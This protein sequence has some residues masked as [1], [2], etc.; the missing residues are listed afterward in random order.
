MVDFGRDLRA[1][2]TQPGG[3]ELILPPGYYRCSRVT[4]APHSD[5]LVLRAAEPGSVAVDSAVELN[6]TSRLVTAGLDFRQRFWLNSGNQNVVSWHCQHSN[7]GGGGATNT[8]RSGV[9]VSGGSLTLAGADVRRCTQDGVHVSGAAS[10][11]VQLLGTRIWDVQDP[12]GVDHNDTIQVR[13]GR[14]ILEDSVL[15]L[16]DQDSPAGN[17]HVQIQSDIA[18]AEVTAR[19]VWATNSG[20]FGWSVD[21]KNSGRTCLLT[22]VDVHSWDHRYGDITV[23]RGGR[24]E[25]TN[26]VTS[27]PSACEVPPDETWRL[28]W[29]Y[30]TLAAFLA[31]PGL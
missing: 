4:S 28:S 19:R 18:A 20:N 10:T 9:Q 29:P 26:V 22:R 21:G 6:G 3:Q 2:I 5:W 1:W 24:H 25:D 30:D 15:G 31:M 14:V 11:L 16:S 13:G 17:G 8:T 23:A 12:D 7:P 27:A